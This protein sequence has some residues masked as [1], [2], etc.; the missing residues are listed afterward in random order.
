MYGVARLMLCYKTSDLYAGNAGTLSCP[1]QVYQAALC[2]VPWCGMWPR[3]LYIIVLKY[4]F[5]AS[6]A[7]LR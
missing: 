5:C 3:M 4:K 2:R 7:G 1:V 6:A